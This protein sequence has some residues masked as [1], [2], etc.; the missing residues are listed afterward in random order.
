MFWQ[1]KESNEFLESAQKK[2]LSTASTLTNAMTDRSLVVQGLA[3]LSLFS[4]T[5]GSKVL[6]RLGDLVGKELHRNPSRRRAGNLHIEK[7]AGIL[8]GRAVVV[9][10]GAGLDGIFSVQAR[11]SGQEEEDE[12]T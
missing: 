10:N 2:V 4:R 9:G 11:Q 7:D 1:T 5:Q 6:G 12:G 8:L 3:G